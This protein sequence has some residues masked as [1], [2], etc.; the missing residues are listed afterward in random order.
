MRAK[1]KSFD[2]YSAYFG[3]TGCCEERVERRSSI[4]TFAFGCVLCVL[5][6][7]ASLHATRARSNNSAS[8]DPIH[9]FPFPL[10]FP[11]P[12]SL[13]PIFLQ[14]SDLLQHP[15]LLSQHTLP[16]TYSQIPFPN[17]ICY[18]KTY[19]PPSLPIPHPSTY[20][21]RQV[22]CEMC[23]QNYEKEVWKPPYFHIPHP[24]WARLQVSSMNLSLFWK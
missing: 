13:P 4:N 12:F 3:G 7:T 2:G 24:Q 19:I 17:H 23:Q 1:S 11:L 16:Y 10:S 9:S 6:R 20:G 5:A 14:S 22:V 18:L 15:T 8:M 21:L